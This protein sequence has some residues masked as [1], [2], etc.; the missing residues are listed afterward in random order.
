MVQPGDGPAMGE[1][2]SQGRVQP[3]EGPP[4][5]GP[6][7]GPARRIHWFNYIPMVQS[8]NLKIIPI[9]AP[10]NCRTKGKHY[11]ASYDCKTNEKCTVEPQTIV[12]LMNFAL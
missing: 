5:R 11:H 1:L 10:N 7:G 2:S 3:V 6:G 8:G 9:E 4:R 12:K